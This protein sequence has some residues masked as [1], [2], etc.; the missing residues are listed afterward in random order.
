M[1]VP[2]VSSNRAAQFEAVFLPYLNSAYNLARWLTRNDHDAED[3]VQEAY[4]RA[5][6]AFDSFQAERDGRPWFLRIV[7]NTCY[8]WMRQNRPAELVSGIDEHVDEATSAASDAESALIE[9]ANA[10]LVRRALEEIPLEYR[11]VLI[12]REWEGQSYKEIAQIVGAPLGTVMS[13]LSR[14]RRELQKRLC[15]TQQEKK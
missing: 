3:V 10:Q 1:Q 11:E 2:A 7:R 9:K 4:L 12:L 5:M 14:G 13:R 8:T 6:Q 15:A